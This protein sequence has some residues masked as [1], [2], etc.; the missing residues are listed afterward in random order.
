MTPDH[1]AQLG[2][3]GDSPAREAA[4]DT[5]ATCPTHEQLAMAHFRHPQAEREIVLGK[6]VVAYAVQR[7]RRRSI[8]MVV[9]VEGLTVRAP[10]W[11][12]WA[13]EG[14]GPTNH[15]GSYRRFLAH[16]A[17]LPHLPEPDLPAPYWVG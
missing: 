16:G 7:A 17:P 10:R 3:W 4:Q 8:G 9:G 15:R 13:D 11:V 1:P 14:Q 2:L 6:A 5:L 12:A